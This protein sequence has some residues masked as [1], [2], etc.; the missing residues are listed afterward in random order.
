VSRRAV[1]IAARVMAHAGGGEVLVSEAVPP[2]VA[3]PHK[4]FVDR[5]T[6]ELKGVPGSWRLLSA[7]E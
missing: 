5:G 7:S 3:G 6:Y 1:V 4:P 2:L